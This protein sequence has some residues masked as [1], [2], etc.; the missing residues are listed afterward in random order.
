MKNFKTWV[1]YIVVLALCLT[2]YVGCSLGKTAKA[3]GS[4]QTTG[5]R[6]PRMTVE[7]KQ[8]L[9]TIAPNPE[10]VV[11]ASQGEDY[12]KVTLDAI[13]NAGGL[14][15][16]IKEGDTVLIK[17]NLGAY[18]RNGSSDNTDYRVVQAVVD[19]AREAKAGRI[20][21]AEGSYSGNVFKVGEYDKIQGVELIDLNQFKADEC[22]KL[23]A[24]NS[25]TKESFYIPKVYMDADVVITCAKLKTYS[26]T[27]ATLSLKNVF[28]VPPASLYASMGG[29]MKLHT[30][31]L[32]KA[33]VDLNKI[34]KPDFAVID[35]M[36]GGEGMGP[37]GTRPVKSNVVFA[38]ADLVATDTVAFTFMGLELKDCTHIQKAAEQGL[39]ICDLS[40]IKVEGIDLEKVKMKFKRR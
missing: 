18:A 27:G 29:K 2:A 1:S 3:G 16:I 21:I 4:N 6:K 19:A 33:I 40:K 9:V 15:S 8:K 10:P 26:E 13:K 17:P 35:G 25:M 28:G 14:G 34:R 24:E 11:G 23:E 22:Y 32:D 30:Y 5:E 37:M 38:G 20:I 39:G 7:E 36:I 31:G 12:E